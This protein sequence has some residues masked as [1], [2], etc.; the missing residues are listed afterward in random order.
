MAE[1]GEE[2]GPKYIFITENGEEKKTSRGY[3]SK[4]IAH[5]PNGDVYDGYFVEGIREGRGTY[6]YFSNGEKYD[7]DW[8]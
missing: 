5:Y 3:T 2:G 6:R 7:G 1:E 4:A 8:I